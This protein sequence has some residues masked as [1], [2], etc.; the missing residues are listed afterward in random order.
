MRRL[1]AAL[2]TGTVL[3]TACSTSQSSTNEQPPD[4]VIPAGPAIAAARGAIPAGTV[5]PL[6]GKATALT[7]DETTRTVAIA[8]TDPA[9]LL[10]YPADNLTATPR[11]IPL[12]GPVDQLSLV[13]G[14]LLAPVRANG[15][16]LRITLPAG[17]AETFEVNG[18]PLAATQVGDRTIVALREPGQ[19]IAVLNA[20]GK[21]ER[22]I[23]EGFRGVSAVLPAGKKVVVLDELRTAVIEVDP[24]TGELGAGLRAGDATT[25]A[26]TDRF[27][28][29]LAVDTRGGELLAFSTNPLIMRQR[30]PVPG[31]PYGIAYDR[32]RDLAWITLTE[33][34]EVVGYNVASGSP[35][36]KYR[37]ATVHQ[38]NSVTVDPK[39]GRVLVASADG[40]GV[41][42]VQP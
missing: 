15:K 1:M 19:G 32:T 33:R 14:K 30:Y 12:P 7:L 9:R 3:L 31:A 24:A 2:L 20:A 6:P 36:E 25:H 28:R 11:E 35:E 37:F 5:T 26:V 39:S 13:D 18:G 40:G 4:E 34:D 16:L 8:V 42:V 21:L 22:T 41:Q 27:G 10:L 38:P 29:V 23:N 17:T